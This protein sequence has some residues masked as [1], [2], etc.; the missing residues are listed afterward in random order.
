VLQEREVR[1]LGSA[2][3][4]PID[5]RV[6]AA[7][8]LD[9]KEMVQ[10]RKFREDL[11]YRLNVVYLELP[12][13]RER[14]EDISLLVERFLDDHFQ[15]TGQLY[16]F[17]PEAMQVLMKYNWPGNVRELQNCV[18]QAL[19]LSN[20]KQIRPEDISIRPIVTSP[21]VSAPQDTE[22]SFDVYSKMAIER[23]LASAGGDIPGAAKILNVGISTLYR[24]M[25]KLGIQH[26]HFQSNRSGDS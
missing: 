7:S 2:S 10:D 8:K 18:D 16:T 25:K 9:L 19:A 6:I 1:P 5:V 13:L 20:H 24:K 12:S 26:S 3:A 23:A 11:F 15:R 14:L 4:I 22:L 17:T 21:Q